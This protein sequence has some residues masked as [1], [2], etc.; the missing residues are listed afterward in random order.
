MNFE[1]WENE[2][3]RSGW[4]FGLSQQ[5]EML[6]DWRTDRAEWRAELNHARSEIER[7]KSGLNK[8]TDDPRNKVGRNSR[9]G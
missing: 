7:L 9:P 3:A 2:I 1:S 4:S 5:K 6:S 8:Q